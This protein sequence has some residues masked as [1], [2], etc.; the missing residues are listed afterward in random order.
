MYNVT[1]KIQ[2]VA[3]KVHNVTNKIHNE[4]NKMQ[5]ATSPTCEVCFLKNKFSFVWVY[6]VRFFEYL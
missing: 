3:D 6:F 4:A 1:D 2:N 5:N